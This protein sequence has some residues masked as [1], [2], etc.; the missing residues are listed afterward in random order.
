MHFLAAFSKEDFWEGAVLA[1][2]GEHFTDKA[3]FG[4]FPADLFHVSSSLQIKWISS[5]LSFA[6]LRKR[7]R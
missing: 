3:E 7:G 5:D 4:H 6:H 2:E 1:S